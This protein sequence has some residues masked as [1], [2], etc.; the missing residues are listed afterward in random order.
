M[1]PQAFIHYIMSNAKSIR[2]QNGI[3]GNFKPIIAD[4]IL[5]QLIRIFHHNHV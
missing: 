4:E 2:M 3:I 5:T 1:L